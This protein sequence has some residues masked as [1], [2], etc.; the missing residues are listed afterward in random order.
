MAYQVELG[1]FSLL[2]F[3]SHLFEVAFCVS[4]GKLVLKQRKKMNF[5]KFTLLATLVGS[6]CFAQTEN[7][8]GVKSVEKLDD[9]VVTATRTAIK[10][11]QVA[12]S[13][14]VITAEDIERR[15]PQSFL[16]LMNSVPGLNI[17]SAGP[18]SANSGISI[19]G[20][21][22]Y[23]TKILINGVTIQ[24]NSSIKP[25]AILSAISLDN[26]ERIEIVRGASSTLYG[27]N[28]MGGVINIITKKGTKAGATG[29]F[30]VE[31]GSEE[32]Q[33][34]NAA[35]R[36]M[37]GAFDYAFST[38][39]LSEKGISAKSDNSERDAFR[40]SSST[41]D[42]GYQINDTLR[43]SGFGRY[44][45]SDQEF[46][47]GV[48]VGDWHVIDLQLGSKL[49]ATELLD[50][51]F[52]TSVA[53]SYTK[54]RRGDADNSSYFKGETYETTW[55]NI[56]RVDERNKFLFGMVYTED[57]SES[58]STSNKYRTDSWFAQ[59]ETE[60]VDNL[61]LT[62]GLRY[63]NNC[64]FGGEMTYSTS[65]A[66]LIEETGT[67]LKT[68]FA[69]GF[70]TPSLYELYQPHVVYPSY[71]GWPA[72]DVRGNSDLEPEESKSFDIGFEQVVTDEVE[73]GMT[74]F[75]S[76]VKNYI[77]WVDRYDAPSNTTFGSYDQ[78]S[79]IKIY[80]VE[81]YIKITPIEAVS[82]NLS[83]TYQHTN[84]MEKEKSPL[85]YEPS[86]TFSAAVNWAVDTQLNLNLN[87]DYVGTR[88][89][90]EYGTRENLHGYTLVNFAASYK[91][92]ESIELYGR[93]NNLLDQDYQLSEGYNTYGI[94]TY[95]GM[96]YLF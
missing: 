87:A 96:K 32:W 41:L 48:S 86:N 34:Y 58:A 73:F 94:T 50:G 62:A 4:I 10:E 49:A 52:D 30:G 91:V 3:K 18:N 21:K 61:F 20:M 72:Y 80:G 59:Y 95:V 26:I 15:Q 83:H 51:K 36:E 66:Y 14:T 43:L 89:T 40:R 11:E 42:L 38:E 37:K 31:F 1:D 65:A 54:T 81:S 7:E 71:G 29:E 23:H 2:S 77:G 90:G 28:A 92:T 68:S 82:L 35:V 19:R 69:T 33:K 53:F 76:K 84:D 93:I 70:R 45:D 5:T 47:N 79:G 13:I 63:T 60:P 6:S 85:P 17:K 74:Y 56:Y 64:E 27:S 22:S 55:E 44:S 75:Q 57:K 24:D 78:V 39:W 16:A 8:Q 67:K 88:N 12:R 9:M 25:S 46:D